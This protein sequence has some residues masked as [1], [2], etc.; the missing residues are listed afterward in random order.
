[1]GLT[2]EDVMGAVPPQFK[3]NIT[4]MLVEQINSISRDPEEARV[5]QESFVSYGD[6]LTSGKYCVKDYLKAV[7]FVSLKSIGKTN[8]DS[9]RLTFPDRYNRMI[10][11]NKPE[12]DIASIISRYGRGALVVKITEMAIIPTHILN[13]SKVQEAINVQ[14]EIMTDPSVSPRTRVEAANSLLTHLKKPESTGTQIN[15]GIKMNDGMNALQA[16][17]T[18]LSGAQKAA[19]ESGQCETLEVINLQAL[20]VDEEDIIDG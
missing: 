1:M 5:I 8:K 7:Q 9:Y 2:L 18:A 11:D 14:H 4:P 13:Q 12:K 17:L 19:I 15:I 10:D 6:V 3:N 20:E 16:Q